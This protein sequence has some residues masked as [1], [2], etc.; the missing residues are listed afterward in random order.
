M[1]GIAI[2]NASNQTSIDY[3]NVTT[4]QGPYVFLYYT[5]AVSPQD[6]KPIGNRVYRYELVDN[7]L[8]NPKLLLDLP[9]IPGPRHNGGAITIGPD[10]NL[11]VAIGDVDGHTTESQNV[12]DGGKPDGT[13]GI[14]RI[15]QVGKPVQ[16][17]IGNQSPSN[18]YFA[19]G[20]RN[21]FG[22]DFDPVSGHLWDT[23]NGPGS[24]D[25]INLVNPGFNSGW[26][27]IQGKAPAGFDYQQL[28][29]FGGKG[30]YRDPEFSLVD[31]V[32]PSKVLFF[33]SDKLGQ[34]YENDMFV[35]DVHFGRIYDF[36]LSENRTN[37]VLDGPI[38]DKVAETDDEV[39]ALIFGSDFGAISDL[40]VGSD[41]YLYILSFGQ[42]AI[43]RI[44]ADSV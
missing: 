3:N 15:T 5:E 14:L 13:G 24:N 27:E 33:D 19:Y 32:G 2:A 23:E 37:L 41:G 26:L 40:Q 38:A 44:H 39:N 9:A 22:L 18:K 29:N 10:N 34:Q 11:Y 8:V 17:I 30:D 4:P 16:S 7:K 35:A 6:D 25:E 36:N 1:L 21:S 43:Y 12:H 31:T 28:V 42:G 20:V